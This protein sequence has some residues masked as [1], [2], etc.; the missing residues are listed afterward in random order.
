[1]TD[2]DG[3]MP[4]DE[5]LETARDTA[6]ILADKYARMAFNR[7]MAKARE[8]SADWRMTEPA[9]RLVL[10]VYAEEAKKHLIFEP[11]DEMGRRLQRELDE[12]GFDPDKIDPYRAP[13]DEDYPTLG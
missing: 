11:L 9:R 10:R 13:D 7:L 1:M 2:D 6:R 8:A 4:L 5:V 12:A 3:P